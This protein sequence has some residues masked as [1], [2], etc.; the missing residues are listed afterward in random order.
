MRPARQEDTVAEPTYVYEG[1]IERGSGAIRMANL[2]AEPAPV[3]FGVHGAIAQHYVKSRYHQRA[4]R[5]HPRL[6]DRGR[7]SLTAGHICHRAG[8]AERQDRP[9]SAHQRRTRR[10]GDRRWHPRHSSHFRPPSPGRTRG[11]P[12]HGRGS[13]S[14]LP[15]ALSPLS[16][17]A[18]LHRIHNLLP[19]RAC[20]RNGRC[21]GQIADLAVLRAECA[22]LEGPSSHVPTVW[23]LKLK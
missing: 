3:Y 4:S 13:A 12:Q 11:C 14:R 17:P 7:G 5:R 15:H 9:G 6:R 2:P 18:P 23:P 8:S 1:K 21:A 22:S 10:G 20:C 19:A 16:H